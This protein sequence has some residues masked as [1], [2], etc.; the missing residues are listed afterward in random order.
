MASI[1]QY[2]GTEGHLRIERVL[3]PPP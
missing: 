2:P 1:S 3:A